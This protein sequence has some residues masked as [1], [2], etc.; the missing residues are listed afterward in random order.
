MKQKIIHR[1][2]NQSLLFVETNRERRSLIQEKISK[3]IKLLL[4]LNTNC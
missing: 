2:A 3:G 1:D 4:V